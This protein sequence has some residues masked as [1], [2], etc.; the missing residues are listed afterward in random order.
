MKD[1]LRML[2]ETRTGRLVA[3]FGFAGLLSFLVFSY[4]LLQQQEHVRRSHM[5]QADRFL[6]LKTAYNDYQTT[7]LFHIADPARP[8]VSDT[9]AQFA[10]LTARLH[11]ADVGAGPEEAATLAPVRAALQNIGPEIF[12]RS[13]DWQP[14]LLAMAGIQSSLMEIDGTLARRNAAL[15][16]GVM[17]SRIAQILMGLSAVVLMLL[18][19]RLLI[20]QSNV[21]HL[22]RL[23]R[24]TIDRKSAAQIAAIEASP[25]G[26]VILDA[27]GRITYMNRAFALLHFLSG[28]GRKEAI[29]KPWAELYDESSARV[30]EEVILPISREKGFWRGA[31]GLSNRRGQSFAAELSL[32]ALDPEGPHGGGYIG[33]AVDTS[34]KQAREQENETLRLQYYQAQKMESLGRLAGGIA[35]DF[36]N[37]LAA[38]EGYAQ[39]LNEDLEAGSPTHGFAEKILI[40]TRRA[41]G[42]IEQ[43]LNF[44]RTN[45]QKRADI[46]LGRS[47][48][49]V[50]SLLR[51]SLSSGVTIETAPGSE[52]PVTVSANP[53]QVAQAVMNLCVNAQDAMNGQGTLQVAVDAMDAS[54]AGIAD[55][56]QID[57]F[58]E[59][60][61]A[62]PVHIETP[63]D[64]HTVMVV[65]YVVAGQQY[66]RISVRDS[67]SG[68]PRAVAEHMFEPFYT[69]KDVH[70][71][72]GLG[73]AS[74][75][76]ILIAH[77]GFLRVDTQVGQGTAFELFFPLKSG[78]VVAKDAVHAATETQHGRILVV[79]DEDEVRQVTCMMLTR[80][81]YEVFDSAGPA[82]ALDLIRD[83][84]H[85]FDAV[86]SDFAMPGMSGADFA[87]ASGEIAPSLPF[88][89]ITGFAEDETRAQLGAVPM[90][91]AI[92]KKPVA[93]GDLVAQLHDVLVRD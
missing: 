7:V 18:I 19:A 93:A 33:T 25:D 83:N 92:L 74:V 8:P 67:G 90:V 61:L 68:I 12:A 60:S 9:A 45:D 88:V 3:F 14:A 36:N 47:V 21:M 77:H 66:A 29:G 4:G 76:G 79:D 51:A 2:N 30:V 55:Q 65:G 6:A 73:L 49:E 84:P 46:D 44:S 32:T 57:E 37:I 41:K 38:I 26:V 13:G 1:S 82:E 63:E 52:V 17:V 48:G 40:A 89:I 71:G 28:P 69:T 80:A 78:G 75:H 72:T 23:E 87:R 24:D 58:P 11:E 15:E 43:I 85:G 27:E 50:V 31:S 42:L 53:A 81:G 10:T 5:L 70:K 22:L 56:D 54:A 35:H 59:D 39:F 20:A 62:A 34:E 91:R 64:G 16:N 86:V